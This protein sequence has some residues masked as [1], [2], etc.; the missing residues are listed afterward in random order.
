MIP[1]LG[2]LRPASPSRIVP[3]N[4]HGCVRSFNGE[5]L[6]RCDQAQPSW[7]SREE[8]VKLIHKVGVYKLGILISSLLFVGMARPCGAQSKLSLQEAIDQALKTRASLKAEAQRVPAAQGL[9]RQ[10]ELI[11]NP[12]FQFENQNLRPGQIYTRDVDTYAYLTQPLDV[13]GKRKQRIAVAAKEVASTQAQYEL[14]QRQ[15]AQDIKR[16]YWTARGA[17]ELRDLLNASVDNF[18]KIL[19]YD[20]AQLSVGAISEQDFLRIRLEDERLKI[21]ANLAVLEATRT[22]VRLQREMGQ[23]DFPDLVLSEPLDAN[24]TRSL[25]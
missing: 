2:I 4:S 7:P 22:R 24:Q 17:Q 6:H 9:K 19:D 12:I 8:T 14:A 16:S 10:A 23:T 13:F 21:S 3:I 25:Q 18:Q 20:S 5:L 15:I 11:Q 1:L